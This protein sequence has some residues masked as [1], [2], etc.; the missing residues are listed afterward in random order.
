MRVR[1]LRRDAGGTFGP[2]AP[3]GQGHPPEEQGHF[4]PY[5]VRCGI[6]LQPVNLLRCGTG[7]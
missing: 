2:P 5:G 6:G 1:A 4:A 3:E 7:L